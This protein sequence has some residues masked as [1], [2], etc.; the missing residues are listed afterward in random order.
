M[1][2]SGDLSDNFLPYRKGVTN[3]WMPG[4]PKRKG[5]RWNFAC[6]LFAY[7][8][9]LCQLIPCTEEKWHPT[10]LELMAWTRWQRLHWRPD[11]VSWEGLA[12]SSFGTLQA[13]DSK[14]CLLPG[15]SRSDDSVVTCA[16]SLSGLGNQPMQ[17]GRTILITNRNKNG[18]D[19]KRIGWMEVD[20]GLTSV[21]SLWYVRF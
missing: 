3:L 2:T 12:V 16:V 6:M 17:R 1:S 4:G 8:R 15:I 13:F 7:G 19:R 14:S 5:L 18:E 11:D 10:E 20:K 21:C 9:A